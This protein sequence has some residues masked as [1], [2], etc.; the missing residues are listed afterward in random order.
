M[1]SR[2]HKFSSQILIK[3]E[4][5]KEIFNKTANILLRLK[6][7]I[8]KRYLILTDRETVRET[9]EHAEATGP[10]SQFC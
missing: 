5:S 7:P 8:L 1:S 9:G 4:I 3:I 6:I 2:K 10:L